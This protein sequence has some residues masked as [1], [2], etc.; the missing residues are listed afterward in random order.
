AARALHELS[1]RA[2]RRLVSRNAATLPS[3]LM[4]AELFGNA[5]NYPNPGMAERAGLI[6]EANGGTLFLDEIGELPAE[7]QA[8]LLRVLDGDGEY[9]RLGDA[10][11]RR[12]DFRLVAA[13]NRDPSSL[14][15]DFL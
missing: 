14:K 9:Q 5:K 13:T 11:Q 1:P 2:E 8:H 6:G 12:S 4:D 15:H 7:L 10:Q 3:G